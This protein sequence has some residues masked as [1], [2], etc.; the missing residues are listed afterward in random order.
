MSD[1]RTGCCAPSPSTNWNST[2]PGSSWHRRT[3]LESRR[4]SKATSWTLALLPVKRI[5]RW[6]PSMRTWRSLRVVRPN[7]PFVRA[8]SS[9]PTRTRVRSSSS[10][11]SAMTRSC[12]S[13]AR[14]RSSRTRAPEAGKRAAERL[15]EL[16]LGLL[17]LLAEAGVVAVLL[18]ASGIAPGRLHVAAGVGRDPHVRPGRR[19]GERG[20]PLERL[21]VVQ[22]LACDLVQVAGAAAAAAPDAGLVIQAEAQRAPCRSPAAPVSVRSSHPALATRAQARFKRRMTVRQP[23]RHDPSEVLPILPRVPVQ[24]T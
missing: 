15:E 8:Y 4:S 10:T 9:F 16:E 22:L 3:N 11:T 19:D 21:A 18:A 13:P 20:D 1:D 14:P 17:L 23:S 6:L 5:R 7:E 24:D 12:G 2:W